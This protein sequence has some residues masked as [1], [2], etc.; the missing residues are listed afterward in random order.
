M[1]RIVTQS[2]LR[3]RA[4]G[5]SVPSAAPPVARPASSDTMSRT[6]IPVQDGRPQYVDAETGQTLSE[7]PEELT[8]LHGNLLV[9]KTHPRIVFR[10]KLDTLMAE[11]LS[12]QV[13][14]REANDGPLSDH[15]EEVLDFSRAILGAE[16]KEEVLP[17]IHM[18]GMDTA[19]IRYASHHVRESC[20]IEHPIPK[21]DMGALAMA[22][23]RLR[24][25]IRETELAAAQAF[26]DAEGHC[27]RKDIVEGLNRLS[28]YV[29][30]LFCR[31]VAK[32]RS[33]KPA[34][35]AA[36]RTEIRPGAAITPA[37]AMQSTV[38]A[39]S[40]TTPAIPVEVSARHVHLSKEAL[41]ILFGGN[42]ALTPVRALSQP[43]QFLSEEKIKVISPKGQFTRVSILGPLRDEVQV[44][45]SLSDARMLGV[46]APIRLSGDLRDAA[47]V[48][49]VGPMGQIDARGSAIVAKEHL[50]MPTELAGVYGVHDGEHV[51]IRMQS[52]RGAT[53]DDVIV[54]VSDTAG[55]A[56]HIDTDQAN[57]A[58]VGDVVEG[59]ILR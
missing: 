44:E 32:Q 15:L 33:R 49:L 23:N 51:R 14:A 27:A 20:G 47:D 19:G 4:Q 28:S 34:G 30:L 40:A 13:L 1:T 46:K 35:E 29:Y 39:G 50:H 37:P 31:E 55:L 16:V 53:L 57:A 5:V 56:V 18:E 8:H 12:T 42:Y 21:A 24:T 45:I 54:R 38:T 11:I 7:K 41:C 36:G 6:P 17:E 52:E 25:E 3:A 59:Y 58:G 22:L 48:T 9:Y 43:G 10:G 2:E 26:T